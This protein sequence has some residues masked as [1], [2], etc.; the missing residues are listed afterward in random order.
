MFCCRG[1][2]GDKLMEYGVRCEHV[3]TECEHDVVLDCRVS[4]TM[5]HCLI[6]G[7]ELFSCLLVGRIIGCVCDE[8]CKICCDRWYR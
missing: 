3:G 5:V 7:M 1:R 2:S 6:I 4:G 8:C